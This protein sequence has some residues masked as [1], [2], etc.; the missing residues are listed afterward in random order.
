MHLA[1]LIIEPRLRTSWT[2]LDLGETLVRPYWL[3]AFLL[4]LTLAVPAYYLLHSVLG[5]YSVW[6]FFVIWWFK[7]LFERP[8]LFLLSKE[9][10]NEK[11]G[12]L[13]TLGSF[14]DWLFPGWL[15][16]FTF[17]RLT[18][19][20]GMRAPILLLERTN[21]SAYRARASVLS[22][23]YSNTAGWHNVVLY[24]FEFFLYF[25]ILALVALFL[26]ATTLQEF[27]FYTVTQRDSVWLDMAV[28]VAMAAIAPF[29][30]ASSFLLYISKRIEVE[31]WDIELCFR[32]WKADLSDQVLSDR[33]ATT[34]A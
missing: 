33:E 20:R 22:Q 15:Y 7:P 11:C 6:T 14:K 21:V 5:P 26:P 19:V 34:H 4:Y 9:I 17:A 3:R 18:P 1:K 12:Y 2:A 8:I 24:H 10:F 29:Y 27:D 28:V 31:G 25:S 13:K 23:G 32:D 30:V 16:A